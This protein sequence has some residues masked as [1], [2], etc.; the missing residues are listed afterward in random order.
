[1]SRYRR[2]WTSSHARLSPCA[3][4]S[5]ECASVATVINNTVVRGSRK[6]VRSSRMVNRGAR[7][8]NCRL[9]VTKHTQRR[10]HFLR[11]RAHRSVR[12]RKN[13]EWS[14]ICRLY[15]FPPSPT[16]L[17]LVLPATYAEPAP[18]VYTLCMFV[19]RYRFCPDW[20][21]R[22]YHRSRRRAH[23]HSPAG[24]A[25]ALFLPLFLFLS[26]RISMPTRGRRCANVKGGMPRGRK[27]NALSRG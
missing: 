16:C 4:G 19:A 8:V 27:E 25:Y 22:L 21:E 9:R 1:M 2:N 26:R 23:V 12:S 11:C 15:R 7:M 17:S 10:L 13:R 3:R 6:S 24:R 18:R 5:S 20:N 14:H